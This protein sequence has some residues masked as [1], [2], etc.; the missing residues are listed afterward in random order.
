MPASNEL[1]Q[2]CMECVKSAVSLLHRTCRFCNEIEFEESVLCD[3]NRCIQSLL[4]F[5]CHNGEISII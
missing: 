4:D 1:P 3:L 5:E 2:K